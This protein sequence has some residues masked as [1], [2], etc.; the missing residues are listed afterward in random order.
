MILSYDIG[1]QWCRHFIDRVLRSPG[2]AFDQ[3]MEFIVA[4]GK[5]HLGSHV[6]G[7]FSRFTLNFIEGAGHVDGEIIETLWS[8]LNS[9]SITARSKSLAHREDSLH[10]HIA[11][12]NFKKMISMGKLTS[13]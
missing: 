13:H 12:W 11:D 1:C 2:L 6:H 4:V 5:F 9:A 8:A 7:C 10:H 3:Q